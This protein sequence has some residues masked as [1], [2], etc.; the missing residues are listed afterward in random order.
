MATSRIGLP[1]PGVNEWASISSEEHMMQTADHAGGKQA[2]QGR[3]CLSPRQERSAA[4]LS[5]CEVERR[6][7]EI[8]PY[9][10][11]V[12]D[13]SL[14]D[15]LY[16]DCC[17]EGELQRKFR[18]NPETAGEQLQPIDAVWAPGRP[19]SDCISH[20]PF[21]YA[22]AS[23]VFEHVPNPL[24]WLQ[25]IVN[26]LQPGSMIALVIPDHRRTIDYYRKPTTFSQVMGWSVEKP[27]RPT[28]SQVMEFLSESFEDDG[29]V[30]FN[31]GLPPFSE[32][33]RHYTD[34]DA[35]GFAQFVEREK[36][37][38]DV[39][40]TVWTPESFVDVFS[41]VIAC[42]QLECELIGPQEDFPGRAPEEFLVYL[43]KN[44]PAES[45]LPFVSQV[46]S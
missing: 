17:G 32:L 18:E 39:H 34:Q 12:A 43:R 2:L 5:Q 41:R 44:K 33:K 30:D 29:T 1:E 27:V 38:L 6:G 24:G 3:S 15:V 11:P 14:H 7:L 20:E 37:Y 35:L 8:G 25:E 21:Y 16:V 23:R 19:L 28:P 45:S 22:V 36:Y 31:S 42:G 46:E 40:C 9:F 4:I 26:V 10:R 13:K